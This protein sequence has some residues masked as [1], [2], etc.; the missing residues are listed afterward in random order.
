MYPGNIRGRVAVIAKRMF[1]FGAIRVGVREIRS[2][3]DAAVKIIRPETIAAPDA[4]QLF[5][6]EA[7]IL[8]QLRHPRIVEYLS[9]G[10]HEGRMFLAME[11]VPIARTAFCAA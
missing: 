10:V 5:L 3:C 7:S 8:S 9:L 11:F 4:V 6:R 1:H 2:Q